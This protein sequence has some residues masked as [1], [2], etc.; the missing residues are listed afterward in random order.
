LEQIETNY[1][2]ISL[3]EHKFEV[4]Y[5]DFEDMMQLSSLREAHPD[6]Y[7]I[8]SVDKIYIWGP[9]SIQ[10]CHTVSISLEEDLFLVIKILS[11]VFLRQFYSDR[12]V[13]L[14]R[15]KMHVYEVT[16]VSE[17]L[18]NG[19]FNGMAMYKTYSIHFSPLQL[20]SKT[21]IGLSV[22]ASVSEEIIWSVEDFAR[23]NIQYN[24]LK[25]NSESGKIFIN[26]KSKYRLAHTFEYASQLKIEV[27]RFNYIQNEYKEI[28]DFIRTY[29]DRFIDVAALPNNLKITDIESVIFLPS[30]EDSSVGYS[31]LST[32]ESY[33]YNGKYPNF[34][35]SYNNRYK[36][37]YN[38]PFSYDEFE[39]RKIN[40]SIIFLESE[41]KVVSKFFKSVQDELINMFKIKKDNF[42]YTTFPI[43]DIRLSLYQKKM[44]AISKSNPDL[45]VV[46]IDAMHE[47]L[48][49]SASP[50]FFCKS[51]FIKQG[52]NTQEIQ[53]QQ[54]HKFIADKKQNSPNYTD[55]NLAL[56]IYAK[57]GGMAW[58]IKPNEPR[59]ELVIGIGATTDH[60]GQPI[61]GLT[62]VFRGDGKY[63]FGKAVSV[64]NMNNYEKNLEE[65]IKAAIESCIADY[66]IDT[67]QTVYLVFHIFKKAGKDNEIKALRNV[68]RHFSKYSFEYTF[69][70]IGE[71]HNLRFF[72]YE[73]AY[74]KIKFDIK[75]GKAQNKR[76]VFIRLTDRSGFIGLKPT[77]SVFL[78]VDVHKQSSFID[79]EYVA[80]QVYQFA[81]I[82]HTSYNKSGKP[83][84]IKYPN[85]MAYFAEKLKDLN[86]FYLD[87]IE[88]PD[89]SLWFI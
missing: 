72:T 66:T 17:P 67:D 68:L 85:L 62:S 47:G 5:I 77:S 48:A 50:Y 16:L 33:F 26:S 9:V 55:H 10:G 31:V 39:N 49:T 6:G 21:I 51:E 84:T 88:M 38:K 25:L 54:V 7:F 86:G 24:D 22:S 69:V 46:I 63:L 3:S 35:N 40:I 13:F 11:E 27:D 52:I 53:I 15:R 56:N 58:T 82:S 45:V 70:H 83:V 60:D 74:E 19:Q 71:G 28:K 42:E 36:I 57:L 34:A 37:S 76:G 23:H 75:N 73:N 64:T 4:D 8:H 32:P 87:E 89:N 44:A 79:L 18:F 41:H 12:S 65:I 43:E 30:N 59:N 14:V 29:F 1:Y 61:L 80:N 78:K 81:E 2:S 20:E